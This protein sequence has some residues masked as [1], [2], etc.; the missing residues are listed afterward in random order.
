MYN[1]KAADKIFVFVSEQIDLHNH[2]Y[3]KA[4]YHNV[5]RIK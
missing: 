5:E 3:N 2:Y 1:L 4:I